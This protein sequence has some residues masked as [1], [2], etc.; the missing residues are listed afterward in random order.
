VPGVV[1]VNGLELYAVTSGVYEQLPV[2][3]SG[4][5]TL[6]LAAWQLVELLAV[7]VATGTDGSGVAVPPLVPPPVTDDSVAVPVVPKVC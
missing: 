4:K 7:S 1:E 5:S 2:D 3:A 6:T